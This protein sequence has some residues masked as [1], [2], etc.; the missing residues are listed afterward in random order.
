MLEAIA[1]LGTGRSFRGGARTPLVQFGA[2]A[3]HIFAE[4]Q[5]LAGTE[6]LG[7]SR[8]ERAWQARANGLDLASLTE[9]VRRL[10]V[11]VMEPGS[12]ALVEGGS[13]HRRKLLDWL[14]FH[15]EPG[16]AHAATRYSRVLKQRNAALK[17]D[18]A[19]ALS[20][21]IWDHA[22]AEAGA[23]LA[24]Y[25]QAAW[26]PLQQHFADALSLALPELGAVQLNFH[27]GWPDE[28]GLI[29]ALQA[30]LAVDLGRGFSSRGPHR[31]D[32]TLGFAEAHEKTW[33]SRGQE[34][35][36]FLAFAVAI[37]KRFFEL[38][39]ERAL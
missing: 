3:L 26:A 24:S 33:L 38:R 25:R 8:S 23:L 31:A 21:G 18:G 12:H 16:F 17:Q 37:L 4:V 35:C 29:E 2:E 10:P 30:R 9:L 11:L 19:N 27:Q 39:G 34:K 13:E 28:Q 14:L 32:W 20:L 1:L 15:V 22:L 7:F 5:S 36:V 6:S